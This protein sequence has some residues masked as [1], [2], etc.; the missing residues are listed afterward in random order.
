NDYKSIGD[1]KLFPMEQITLQDLF[2]SYFPLKIDFYGLEYSKK[3]SFDVSINSVAQQV[4]NQEDSPSTSLIIF[5][6]H[7]APPIVTTSEEQTSLITLDEADEFNQED[8]IDFNRNTIFVPYDALNFE[9]VE[10]STTGLDLS[11]MHEFHQVH[12]LT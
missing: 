12:P 10:S 7:E 11:N 5:E 6:E 8:S 3:R 9:G 1:Y 2:C 4:H